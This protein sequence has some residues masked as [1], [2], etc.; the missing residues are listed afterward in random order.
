V[1]SDTRLRDELRYIYLP[2]LVRSGAIERW[3][4]A[5][6]R[7]IE[8]LGHKKL[9]AGQVVAADGTVNPYSTLSLVGAQIGISKVSYQDD[10]RQ[11]V[12]SPMLWAAEMPRNTSAADIAQAINHRA[13]LARRGLSNLFLHAL[14]T[15]KE[16]EI[17]LQTP[18]KTFKLIQGPVFPHEMLSGVGK[19]HAMVTCLNLIAALIEDGDYA[20]IVSSTT[21]IELLDLGLA[22]DARE[23]IVV[24]RG[25]DVLGEFL[26]GPDRTGRAHYTRTPIPEYGNRSQIDV[27]KEFMANYGPRVVQGVLRA[28]PQSRPYVFFCNADNLEDAVH[29]LLADAANTGMRGFP[30]LL[31][32]ADQYCSGSFAGSEHT[33]R[34]NAEFIRATGGSLLYQSERS[35]RD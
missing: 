3:E 11:I 18:P 25:T 20:T 5:D 7:Y 32:L 1:E 26:D 24:R 13:Q 15:Y 30:L 34:M 28:H 4:R 14:M 33:V 10:A 6:D 22:L 21:D 16:R 2:E 23:Y 9:Y 17:L 29:V 19:A 35:T 31:D 8:A 27:I 12:L